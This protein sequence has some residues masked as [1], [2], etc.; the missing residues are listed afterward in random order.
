[1]E[2]RAQPLSLSLSCH[3]FVT[4]PMI[5]KPHTKVVGEMY[6]F[7]SFFYT[8]IKF[9]HVSM[10]NPMLKLHLARR[11]LCL[12]SSFQPTQGFLKC[13]YMIGEIRSSYSNG[14]S[15]YTLSCK[16]TY[17][18][19]HILYPFDARLNFLTF[20][21]FAMGPHIFITITICLCMFADSES[22]HILAHTSINVLNLIN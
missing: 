13:V 1:M 11:S 22:C 20:T 17:A 5:K 2:L 10:P 19:M 18:R 3:Q 14:W 6:A 21:F 15:I 7:I 4:A 9:L 16:F 8:Y 12:Q